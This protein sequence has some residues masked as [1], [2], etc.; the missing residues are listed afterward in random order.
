MRRIL[1]PNL[2]AILVEGNVAHPV[3]SILDGPV[4][5]RQRQ[6]AVG[7]RALG[8]QARDACHGLELRFCAAISP[9]NDARALKNEDLSDVRKVQVVVQFITGPKLA[10]LDATVS[11]LAGFNLRGGRTPTGARECLL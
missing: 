6:Q 8:G 11:L 1:R 9:L 10:D 2:R 5:A 7:G 4:L 3:Q